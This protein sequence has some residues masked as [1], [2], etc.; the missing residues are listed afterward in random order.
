M[1]QMGFKPG[2]K[3]RGMIDGEWQRRR[4]TVITQ[5]S[6]GTCSGRLIQVSERQKCQSFHYSINQSVNLS[7]T[8]QIHIHKN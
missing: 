4:G 5:F 1:K 2:V 7:Q 3:G 6:G 8:T